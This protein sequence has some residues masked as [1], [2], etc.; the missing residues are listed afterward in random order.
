ML[1]AV[2]AVLRRP[3]A[4]EPRAQAELV[5]ALLKAMG[6]TNGNLPSLV[7]VAVQLGIAHQSAY[8]TL[9]VLETKGVVRRARAPTCQAEI[10]L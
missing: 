2:C 7:E 10:R 4:R 6:G 8:R 5:V 3:K 1:E 9:A